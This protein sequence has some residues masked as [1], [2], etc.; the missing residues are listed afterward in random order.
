MICFIK[1]PLLAAVLASITTLT[2]RVTAQVVP[3]DTDNESINFGSASDFQSFVSTSSCAICCFQRYPNGR[4][5]G[6]NQLT[7]VVDCSVNSCLCDG[8][9]RS[10]ATDHLSTCVEFSCF[11]DTRGIPGA[12]SVFDGY[13]SQYLANDRGGVTG[14]SE[15]SGAVAPETVTVVETRTVPV[16]TTES[17]ATSTAENETITI[18]TFVT[19]SNEASNEET[20]KNTVTITT[21]ATTAASTNAST[22]GGGRLSESGKIGVGLGIGIGVPIL[23]ILVYLA[24]R[25]VRWPPAA[26]EMS[27][28]IQGSYVG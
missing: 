11:E 13:C 2:S 28:P 5:T 23:A 15:G 16:R 25:F 26:P 1:S 24:Y 12:I 10:R 19:P 9:I 21:T 7:N 3:P 27:E 20:E 6:F 18:T 4:C 8:N 17:S 22:G 14:T